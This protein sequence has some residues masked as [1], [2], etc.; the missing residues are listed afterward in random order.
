MTVYRSHTVQ[1]R[2]NSTYLAD[3]NVLRYLSAYRWWLAGRGVAPMIVVLLMS[4]PSITLS[5]LSAKEWMQSHSSRPVLDSLLKEL[6]LATTDSMRVVLLCTIS[7]EYTASESDYVNGEIVARQALKLAERTQSAL[8][9]IRALKALGYA[10]AFPEHPRLWDAVVYYRRAV[11]LAEK[12]GDKQQ[13]AYTLR[14][15]LYFVRDRMLELPPS[16][17]RVA[18]FA[19]EA[20]TLLEKCE[21]YANQLNDHTLQGSCFSSRAII[22]AAQNRYVQAFDAIEQ[23]RKHYERYNDAKRAAYCLEYGAQISSRIGDSP[24]ALAAYLRAIQIVD[25]L[26]D[27]G[28]KGVYMSHLAEFYRHQ[29]DVDKAMKYYQQALP[30]VAYYASKLHYAL[31]LEDI[32]QLYQ[33]KGTL[34]SAEYWYHQARDVRAAMRDNS[35]IYHLKLGSLLMA[36]CQYQQALDTL[37]YGFA[38]HQRSRYK[39][40]GNKHTLEFLLTIAEVHQRLAH[41]ALAEQFAEQALQRA[42]EQQFPD[43]IAQAYHRLYVLARQQPMR[44]LEY[45]ERYVQVNDTLFSTEKARSIAAIE[46]RAALE[47]RQ[48]RIQ[49]L[50]QEARLNLWRE[51]WLSVAVLAAIIVIAIILVLY[52]TKLRSEREVRK[53]HYE[54][55]SQQALLEEQSQSIQRANAV[56]HQ[57]NNELHGANQELQRVN[58]QLDKANTFKLRILSMASHDL[59]NPLSSIIALADILPRV[60]H[61]ADKVIE[62]AQRMSATGWR[63]FHLISDLMDVAAQDV[64]AI[65]LTLKTTNVGVLVKTVLLRYERELQR[66]EQTLLSTIPEEWYLTVDPER[67]EQVLDN[68]V[69]NAIKYSP[70]HKTIWLA[71]V[72][73]HQEQQL[74]LDNE[75]LPPLGKPSVM[76]TVRDEGQGISAEDKEKMFGLF[77]R[78]S[79]R[80]TDGEYSTGV[81]LA[82]TKHIVELHGGRIWCDNTSFASGAMFVVELPM[83]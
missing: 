4:L 21:R 15:W 61:Q 79:A 16:D 45:Y 64:G 8:S 37:N 50:E 41:P 52:R 54:I 82:I 75:H 80:P 3:S 17:A 39:Q 69:S 55:I 11:E 58:Q 60:A 66:K 10:H 49:R 13:A 23:A 32:G 22:Y 34:D 30:L 71:L 62:L 12:I 9:L 25:S 77:Q 65:Q 18:T 68:L 76:L 2:A 43:Y 78:L 20:F 59:K 38:L 19:T 42:Q 24:R 63:M 72:L 67:F 74:L 44:A 40:Q 57:R 81:G 29:S 36:K 28:D 48:G 73:N 56:L 5:V 14:W 31:L 35:G 70:H 1:Q 6:R 53:K 33:A 26:K 46:A 47:Q 27:Y 83:L 7:T 51:Q